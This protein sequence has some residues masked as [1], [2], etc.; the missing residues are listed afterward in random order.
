M[1]AEFD[2]A[3]LALALSVPFYVI[4]FTEA[5]VRSF[6]ALGPYFLW[7]TLVVALV[8]L[9]VAYVGADWALRAQYFIMGILVL[10]IVT[11]LGGAIAAFSPETF[12]ANL[13]AE[14][15]PRP[16]G[17][18]FSFWLI[19][20]IYFP[21]VTG[22]DDAALGPLAERIFNLQRYIFAREGHRIPEDDYP[23]EFNFTTPLPGMGPGGK[24]MAPGP[25]S[26]PVDLTGNVLDR[27]KYAAMLKEFYRLRGW[28]ET[29]GLPTPE[30]VASL[31]LEDMAG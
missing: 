16:A 5:L 28:D 1:Y 11:M 20:A 22:I 6:P 4:G 24:V 7:I 15:A 18:S 14:Y 30:T 31:G 26:R 12:Q 8:L 27:E 10:A 13:R 29:T 2:E 23:P 25:G 19:F 17:G 9:V 3:R 21:A